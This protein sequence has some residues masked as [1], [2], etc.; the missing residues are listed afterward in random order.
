MA[1][2]FLVKVTFKLFS[3]VFPNRVTLATGIHTIHKGVL[4]S[5]VWLKDLSNSIIIYCLVHTI[6]YHR[7]YICANEYVSTTRMSSLAEGSAWKNEPVFSCPFNNDETWRPGVHHCLPPK[8]TRTAMPL[9]QCCIYLHKQG[10]LCHHTYWRPQRSRLNT[11]AAM[12]WRL[13]TRDAEQ[14][15]RAW[16]LLLIFFTSSREMNSRGVVLSL[17]IIWNMP[18][19]DCEARYSS[20]SGSLHRNN[21]KRADKHILPW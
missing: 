6:P 11:F 15:E 20:H 13:H 8:A 16:C 18:V 10:N 9:Q 2:P 17:H 21:R 14:L 12:P 3:I 1:V 4:L 5:T 19:I 7:R